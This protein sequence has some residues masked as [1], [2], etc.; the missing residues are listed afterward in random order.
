MRRTNSVPGEK[1]LGCDCGC[2]LR[3]G[4]GGTHPST[5][6]GERGGG[7]D[8]RSRKRLTRGCWP[9]TSPGLCDLGG[10]SE[11]CTQSHL[12]QSIRRSSGFGDGQCCHDF[13]AER[14]VTLTEVS[15]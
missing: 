8:N 4:A 2:R 11:L 3:L 13:A 1:R 12:S 5:A 6:F 9:S 10:T 7:P 15:E 14:R